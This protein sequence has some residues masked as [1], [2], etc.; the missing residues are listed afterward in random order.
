M[1]ALT[2][3]HIPFWF[4]WSTILFTKKILLASSLFY[5]IYTI[6]IGL[7]TFFANCIFIFGGLFIVKKISSSQHVINLILGWALLLTALIQ[8]IKIIWFKPAE[9]KT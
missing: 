9:E 3:M 4:G 6:A 2:V 7:G 1:S 5:N 8:F